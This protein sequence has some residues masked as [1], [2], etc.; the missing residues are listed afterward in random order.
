LLN[1]LDLGAV[2]RGGRGH[3]GRAGEGEG[4]RDE[5]SLGEVVGPFLV[6][7]VRVPGDVHAVRVE[8]GNDH[9]DVATVEGAEALNQAQGHARELI[10]DAVELGS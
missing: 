7:G 3:K 9:G 6:K 10:H 5:V 8:V 4:P 1:E 2:S